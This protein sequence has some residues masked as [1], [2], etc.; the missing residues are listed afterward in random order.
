MT[1]RL[2]ALPPPIPPPPAA[3]DDFDPDLD[4]VRRELAGTLDDLKLV[5]ERRRQRT[6][7]PAVDRRHHERRGKM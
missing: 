7:W 1:S 4:R 3:E 2:W 6:E 5:R